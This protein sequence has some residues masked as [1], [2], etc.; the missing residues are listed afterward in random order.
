MKGPAVVVAWT[1]DGVRFGGFNPE[2]FKSSD[3]YDASFDAFLFCWPRAA[4]DECIK[5]KKVGWA[6][7][8][9]VLLS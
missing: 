6:A 4:P 3:D 5:L 8:L 7:V 2:G 9:A 1:T